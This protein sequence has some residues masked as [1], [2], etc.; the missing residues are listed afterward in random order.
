MSKF[1]V[2]LIRLTPLENDTH[3]FEHS[4]T[5]VFEK[6]DE[7]HSGTVE[8]ELRK[9]LRSCCPVQF[10]MSVKSNRTRTTTAECYPIFEIQG[11]ASTRPRS[12]RRKILR[13]ILRRSFTHC[14]NITLQVGWGS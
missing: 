13:K 10:V 11:K 3:F 4:L 8:T 6:N 1:I 9:N 12:A 5:T 7:T 14:M 2:T